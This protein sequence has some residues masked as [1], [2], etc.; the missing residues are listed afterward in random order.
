MAF[1]HIRSIYHISGWDLAPGQRHKSPDRNNF[2]KGQGAM[3][4]NTH[5]GAK[6]QKACQLCTY[7]KKQRGPTLLNLC[8]QLYR[9][10]SPPFSLVCDSCARA[11]LP[12]LKQ[13]DIL[14][15]HSNGLTREKGVSPLSQQK[16]ENYTG[17]AAQVLPQ[18]LQLDKHICH[19]RRAYD[20]SILGR[21]GVLT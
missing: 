1:E 2:F 14:P 6:G 10:L 16:V 7:Q 21:R 19:A 17:F 20:M 11:M 13:T 12:S 15:S 5:L 18:P 9:P 4:P 3:A 8:F